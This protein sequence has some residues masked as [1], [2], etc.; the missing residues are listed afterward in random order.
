MATPP[1]ES[2]AL[3]DRV[4]P[5]SLTD[6]VVAPSTARMS[7]HSLTEL[8]TDSDIKM[9][10]SRADE[11]TGGAN[12][13]L[14]PVG[15]GYSLTNGTEGASNAVKSSSIKQ[16]AES[17]VNSTTSNGLLS[18]HP[19]AIGAE[20]HTSP[21][22]DTDEEPMKIKPTE[23]ENLFTHHSQIEPS[24]PGAS[25]EREVTPMP[26]QSEQT[27]S[28]PQVEKAQETIFSQPI[29]PPATA[30]GAESN[31]S[32]PSTAVPPPSVDQDQTMADASPLSPTK[33]SRGREEDVTDEPAAKRTKTDDIS[34][35]QNDF[36]V[37]DLP[38]AAPVESAAISTTITPLQSKF[39][40]RTLAALRRTHDARFFKNP[41]DP[42]KLN[43]PS[44]PLTV[45]HPMD[46]H[47]MEEKVKNGAYKTV[48]EVI[49]DFKLMI[50]NSIT[51]NGM[52][53]VV[54]TEGFRLK[55]SWE[56]H[57]T[58]LPSPNEVEPTAAEKKAKKASTAPTKTQPP[59]RE[60]Q[61]K[62]KAAKTGNAS[63]PTTFALG[64]EGLPL[65]RRDSTTVDGRPKR[66]IHP[67]KN[68]DLPYSSKPKKKKFHWELK[69]CE[70]VMD[71]L[72]KPK[73][74]NFAAPFYQPV[75]P[76]ALNIP[77]YH[78]IIKKPMDLSTVRTKLQTGQYENSKEMENDVRLMFKNCYKFNIPGDPTYNA[79]K[80]L[81]E[82]F[83]GKWVQKA[84]WL[85][86]HDPTSTHQSDSSE[87]ES[88]EAEDSNDDEQHE[89]LQLL[90]KQIAEMSKQVE[91]I[92]QKKK[93]TPPGNSKKASKTKSGKKDTKKGAPAKKDKKG[94]AK[95]AKPEKQRWI[96]YR[97]KQ[98]ISNGI[99]TLP[100]SKVQDALHIIQSNVPSL[101]GT[102][103]TEVELDIDELPNNVLLL[104]L[105]FVKKHAPQSLEF[106]EPA[107]EPLPTAVPSKP[108]K[109]KPMN[110]H[111]Q[112]AQIGRLTGTLSKF[113]GGDHPS[114][115]IHSEAAPES[116][117][118]EDSEESEEE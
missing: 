112:E 16:N 89:K 9:A 42:V 85:E 86:A 20:A 99:S 114:D 70:E 57:L 8:A 66:S 91:A 98:I 43:I 33:V 76:V 88:S 34:S 80:K 115:P 56:R 113:R 106:D 17:A 58:K 95:S 52:E 5:L 67:P 107:P 2:T 93:K 83:D 101:K 111:E 35:S 102:D 81:E 10:E 13:S 110:A 60:S 69:F 68:R 118:D 61:A 23:G 96:T 74:Y 30:R 3:E 18:Q 1:P 55:E 29:S 39:F 97:E 14:L 90:Q 44:Y 54:T 51:F 92:R 71:E 100:E 38:S 40:V 79:G 37:P 36:K 22:G 19:T 48:D 25:D 63:S 87:N 4:K 53:H 64:P 65:I 21:K 7:G 15:N 27:K 49:A 6:Q 59:R 62:A 32:Y 47:T 105:N 31:E 45:K 94:G 117:G 26:T 73:Y 108:K 72:H 46:M 103:Q 109:N 41:V 50:D 77:T 24:L 116:S 78:N 11:L 84:R 104:L 82:I 28:P 12:G 75:D